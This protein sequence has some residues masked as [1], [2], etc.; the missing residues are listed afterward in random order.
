MM[1][2]L[3]LSISWYNKNNIMSFW[4]CDEDS[5]STFD[6][7][8]EKRKFIENMDFLFNMSVEE[9]TL[10]KKWEE[11]NKDLKSAYAKKSTLGVYYDM[12]WQPT[13]IFDKELTLS[14]IDLLEPYVEYVNTSEDAT[15]WT[16]VR[17]LIHT[18]SFVANP[19]RNLKFNIKDRVSG[20]ILGQ[21]SLGSDVTSLGVRDSYIGWNKEN[22]FKQGKLNNTAIAS[23]IVSTQPL[24]YN[25]LGGKLIACMATSPVVRKAWED[26]Y[27]DKLIAVGTTSLYGIHSQ[28]NGIPH[29]KTLGESKGKI[30]LKPDDSVYDPWHQ[31]IKENRKAEYEKKITNERIRNGQNMGTGPGASGPVSGIKQRILGMIFSELGIKSTQYNHGFHRGV[32]LAQMYENG[33]EFLR[34]EIEESDLK[35]K[36]KFE[37]GDEYS[38]RWWKKKAKSRYL[39]LY[40][41]DRIKPEVL[42]Y[43]P[44]IGISWDDAKKEFLSEVGR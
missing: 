14:E 23:T 20:K 25:F 17:K 11:W 21:V 42:W 18:M 40:E 6:Y 37:E 26:S 34:N 33:N 10:Y 2:S 13:D 1:V 5:N 7:T 35:M 4:D 19:G 32:Y 24:G 3:S 29:F 8:E 22:K 28:Y 12:L 39:K 9:Q 16:D 15:K 31:W 30:S 41:S 36:N 38:I 44:I 27:G 43:L